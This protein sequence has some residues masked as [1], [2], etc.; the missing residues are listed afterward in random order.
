MAEKKKNKFSKFLGKRA[1]YKEV[2][3]PSKRPSFGL[4]K[5]GFIVKKEGSKK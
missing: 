3:K 2:I 5:A 1:T 4:S